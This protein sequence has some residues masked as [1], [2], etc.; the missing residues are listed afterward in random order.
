AAWRDPVDGSVWLFVANGQGISGLKFD[1]FASV[2]RDMPVSSGSV[3]TSPPLVSV[4]MSTRGGTSPIVANGVLFYAG[5]GFI[6]AL[7]PRT[8]KEIWSDTG[9]G[10]IHW[11]SPIV[12]NGVLYMTDNSPALLA[13][14]PGGVAEPRPDGPCH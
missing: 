11:Q 2:R 14:A 9:V 6:A 5:S 10:Q 1:A 4:W 13:Y 7:D 12:A 3:R 8:G